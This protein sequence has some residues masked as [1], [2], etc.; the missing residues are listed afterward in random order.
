MTCAAT[1]KP[2]IPT[3]FKVLSKTIEDYGSHFTMGTAETVNSGGSSEV[4]L[5]IDV[6]NLE[7]GLRIPTLKPVLSHR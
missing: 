4:L 7:K 2:T 1:T 6:T 5:K 3:G